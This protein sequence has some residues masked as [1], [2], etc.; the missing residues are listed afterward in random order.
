MINLMFDA[1]DCDGVVYNVH[2]IDYDYLR[3]KEGATGWINVVD[4]FRF[5]SSKAQG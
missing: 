1:H 5:G 4:V 3:P 2:D